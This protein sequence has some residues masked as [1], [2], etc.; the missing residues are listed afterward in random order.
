M[1]AGVVVPHAPDDQIGSLPK[2]RSVAPR[3]HHSESLFVR[4]DSIFCN[5]SGIGAKQKRGV[6]ALPPTGRR[7][8][9]LRVAADQRSV[10]HAYD[11]DC[12][13][14]VIA[15][16]VERRRVRAVARGAIE[17]APRVLTADDCVELGH[18]R[19]VCE[20]LRVDYVSKH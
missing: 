11:S 6:V 9:V 8:C 3:M 16:A 14:L 17:E 12:W 7:P 15:M 18:E 4:L 13:A 1:P 2:A 19:R 5:T 10:L 20:Q